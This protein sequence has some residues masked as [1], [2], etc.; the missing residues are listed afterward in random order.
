MRLEQRIEEIHSLP[1]GREPVNRPTQA[2]V[3]FGAYEN[4]ATLS[5]RIARIGGLSSEVA[6]GAVGAKNAVSASAYRSTLVNG[7]TP[8]TLRLF[9]SS[10]HVT[11]IGLDL[12]G[13][14]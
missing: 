13:K 7:Y 3:W 12:R 11:T 10:N 14:S 8:A 2:G 5:E 1:L 9:N 4:V 6:D